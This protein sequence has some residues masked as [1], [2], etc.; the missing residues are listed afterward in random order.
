V[1]LTG[2]DADALFSSGK[3]AMELVGP[4]AAPGLE[5]AGVNFGV[6]KPFTGTSERVT[7][8]GATQYAIPT[9]TDKAHRE[10]AYMFFAWWNSH[11][12]Q[13]S[14]AE[15]SGFPSVR[16][17]IPASEITKNKYAP[18]FG[19]PEALSTA[20]IYMAGVVNGSQI[21]DEVWVPSLE[22]ILNGDGEIEATFAGASK[23]IKQL[24]AED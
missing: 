1:G 10:A 24:L 15:G 23:D 8:A 17:D 22:R 13:V 3:A 9:G 4:W 18:I 5:E 2:G 7:L 14:W 19:D 20:R 6:A 21:T 12:T 11:D 16:T